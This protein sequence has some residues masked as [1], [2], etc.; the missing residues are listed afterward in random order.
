[1]IFG[2]RNED[3]TI[4]VDAEVLGAVKGRGPGSAPIAG[5]A[6]LAGPGDGA[7]LAL[8]VD[9]AEGVA[10]PLQD[11]N[12]AFCINRDGARVQQGSV[13]GH[14]AVF[15]H[16]FLPVAGDGSDHGRRQIDA[17]DPA[18]VEIRHVELFA[19]RVEGETVDVAELCLIR[20]AAVAA[21]SLLAGAG[22]GDDRPGSSVDLRT[23]LFMV[24]AR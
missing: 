24:S 14:G 1:M 16:A 12:I 15:R 5:R 10:A 11:I 19:A 8:T 21:E 3:R 20:P 22:E 13:Y 2:I 17:A 4:A 6:L 18:V 9:D 7:D 23:R